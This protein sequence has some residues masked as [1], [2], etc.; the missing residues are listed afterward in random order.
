MPEIYRDF[1][2]VADQ[3]GLAP[4]IGKA[5]NRSVQEEKERMDR[6][7]AHFQTLSAQSVAERIVEI[8]YPDEK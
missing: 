3:D 2:I 7:R 5:L 8:T 1:M 6:V 4:A